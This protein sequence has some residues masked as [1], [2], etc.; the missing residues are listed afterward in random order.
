[1]G[2]WSLASSELSRRWGLDPET[3]LRAAAV[4]EGFAKVRAK[5]GDYAAAAP[6]LLAAGG[7]Y[8]VVDPLAATHAYADAYV[9]LLQLGDPNAVIAGIA[10]GASDVAALVHADRLS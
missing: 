3:V 9:Y 5:S 7:R 4:E 1:M 8:F 10:S 2:W 6:L